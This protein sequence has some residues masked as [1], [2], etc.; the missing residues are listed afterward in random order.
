MRAVVQRVKQASV[1]VAGKRVGN[2]QNG[3]L[4]FLGIGRDDSEEDVTYMVSKIVNLRA[5][6]DQNGKMNVSLLDVQGEVMVVSQFTLFGDCRKG[7]RP[8]FIE[9]ASPDAAQDLYRSFIR[10]LQQQ[11][12]TVSSGVFQAMMDVSLIN[13]GPVTFLVDSRKLF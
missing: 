3:L 13:D 4:V 5:F 1:T 6:Q 9:A 11:S 12:I 7:R 2:I 10:Q 8:S